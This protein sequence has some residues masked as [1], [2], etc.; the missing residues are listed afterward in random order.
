[1]AIVPGFDNLRKMQL[2][3]SLSDQEMGE[4]VGKIIFKNFRKDE[5][6]L[7][8]DD[9][10]YYMY[11]V[12]SGQ[13]KVVQTSEDGTTIIRAIHA[14]GDS[15]GELSLLDCKTSPAEVVAMKA[16]SVAIIS[17]DNF[18]KLIHTHEKVLDNLLQMFCMRLRDSWE[19]VQMVNFKNSMQR[20]IMLFQQ[21]SVTNG[22]PVKEG[23]L[24]NIRLTH[25]TLASMTGLTR[26]SVTRTLDILQKDKCI[27]MRGRDRKV[28]LLP[29]FLKLGFVS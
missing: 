24:L 11:L 21:L 3:S 2:F 22:E 18:M 5:V 1:M 10:N 9:T 27:N 26:E 17:K 8:Q 16:T 6:I 14:A 20:L 28:I 15:F 13:V 4:V 29:G 25:Q 7:W 23:T 12:M 19:R